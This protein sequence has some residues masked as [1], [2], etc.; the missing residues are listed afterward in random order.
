MDYLTVNLTG[1]SPLLMHSDAGLSPLHPI[2]RKQAEMNARP[3]KE[4]KT[5]EFVLEMARLDWELALYFDEKEGPVLPAQMLE[6]MIRDSAKAEKLGSE[7]KRSVRVTDFTIPLQYDGPR[8]KKG[9]WKSE[10]FF[11]SRGVKIG[12][13]RV[14][15]TRPMFEE[16][17]V[18]FNVEFEPEFIERDTLTRLIEIGGRRVGLGDYRPRFGRF[19]AS[20][21]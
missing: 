9:L 8:D 16:W 17:A 10:R 1:E 12:Q 21:K 2:S 14:L 7:V 13:S 5:T 19:S 11:D 15:R 6:A 18:E 20:F 3:V 4:K